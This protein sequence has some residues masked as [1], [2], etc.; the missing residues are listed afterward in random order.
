M[1]ERLSRRDFLRLS[2]LTA[3]GVAVAACAK[4]PTEAPKVATPSKKAEV[5]PTATPVPVG[6]SAK[7]APIL[8]DQVKAGTLPEL[9]ERLP[10][11]PRVIQVVEEIG[12][13]GGTWRRAFIGPA[14][15][16]NWARVSRRGLLSWTMDGS[17]VIPQVAK[18]WEISDDLKAFTFQL[19][20][21]AKWSD[22]EPFTADDVMFW[23]EGQIM[24][25]E[26][27]PSKPDWM[28]IKGGVGWVRKKGP[29]ESRGDMRAMGVIN[30]YIYSRSI[31]FC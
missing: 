26:M 16:S 8:A 5:K 22:G 27:S 19:R 18:G 17:E 20:K 29:G 9:D 15:G 2:A 1:S 21:K 7:Q 23:W 10:T 25:D 31:F 12:Q 11:E 14:D 6:P 13:Y 4:T 28:K 3:A 30:V 24:N